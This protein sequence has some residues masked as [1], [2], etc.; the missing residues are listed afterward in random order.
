MAESV[1]FKL[2]EFEI[3]I[4]MNRYDKQNRYSISLADFADEV[5][6]T[7]IDQ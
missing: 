1:G 3:R 4:V 5:A 6:P 7:Q 2:N